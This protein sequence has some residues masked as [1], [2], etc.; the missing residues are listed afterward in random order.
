[1]PLGVK[2]PP[3]FGQV[4]KIKTRYTQ[5]S[6]KTGENVKARDSFTYR[7]DGKQPL[8]ISP[9]SPAMPEK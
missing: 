5:L 9:H 6:I 4:V 3:F 7:W 1:M 2:F 8:I